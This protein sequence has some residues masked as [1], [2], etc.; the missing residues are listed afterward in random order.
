MSNFHIINFGCRA[1]QADGGEIEREMLARSFEKAPSIAD[2]RIVILNTCTVTAAADRDARQTVRRVRRE[3]P[4]AKIVVTGC[5]AQRAPEEIRQLP[6]VYCVVGNSHK[7]LLAQIVDQ[8]MASGLQ[9]AAT[10]DPPDANERSLAPSC[11]AEVY[12]DQFTR[13]EK[14]PFVGQALFAAT[15]RTRPSLKI[16]DGC[17]ANC[18]FCIIPAVRGRSRSLPPDEVL[19]QVESLAAEGYKELVLSGIHLGS[20]GRDL[21]A[22]SSLLSL[23]EALENVKDLCRIRL[24]S[25]EP[26]EV[27]EG[28]IDHVTRSRRFAKHL[29]IPLQSGV[30]RILRLMRR[31]YTSDQYAQ[32]VCSIRRK[33]PDAAIGADV[34]TG[35]PGET[36]EEHRATMAFIERSPLTYLHVFSFSP[37]P[38]TLAAEMH[39]QVSPQVI[40]HRSQE[41]RDLG[42]RKKF[43]FQQQMVGRVLSVVTL[44]RAD[45][46]FTDAMSENFLAVH[47]EGPA[48]DPNQIVEVKISGI[49][50]GLLTGGVVGSR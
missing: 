40:K 43:E 44:D 3:N 42:K 28:V 39:G 48:I 8:K 6:G 33:I 49:D 7:H 13:F 10:D 18:S 24:S 26:L 47:V 31:P 30:D 41:L 36:E 4:Q 16:Q 2:A 1:T 34:I 32:V 5:Y 17:D 46:D 15:E 38:G 35:F 25:I 14:T 11:T 19:K 20:Y 50:H 9:E 29:H 37:R 23:L 45:H 12:I 27:S 22:R 21:K